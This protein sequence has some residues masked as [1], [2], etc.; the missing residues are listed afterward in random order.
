MLDAIAQRMGRNARGAAVVIRSPDLAIAQIH[1][2]GRVEHLGRRGI[3]IVE[4]GG[5]D[6]GLERGA[7]LAEGLGRPVEFGLVEGEA[8]DHGQ[9]AA[10][11][12]VHGHDAA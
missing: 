8:A 11:I 5:V 6:D 4:G 10:R 9:N 7:G 3:A 12:G 2:D 1:L